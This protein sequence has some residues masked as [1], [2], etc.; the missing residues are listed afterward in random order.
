[1][2]QSKMIAGVDGTEYS[3]TIEM[4]S[5]KYRTTV[6]GYISRYVKVRIL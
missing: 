4:I 1:M 5:Q 6:G 2:I 3:F